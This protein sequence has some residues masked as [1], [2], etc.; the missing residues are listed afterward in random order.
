MRANKNLLQL[1]PSYVN[2]INSLQLCMHRHIHV[3]LH[4]VICR[5]HI[6][7]EGLPVEARVRL[8]FDDL[9]VELGQDLAP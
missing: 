3:L 8:L 4:L 6:S 1:L 5:G 9:G 2:V 7:A